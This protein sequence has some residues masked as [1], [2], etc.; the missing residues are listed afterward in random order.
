VQRWGTL[1]VVVSAIFMLLIDITVV[2]VALP[3]IQSSLGASFT[4]L[5]WVIDAYSLAL[6]TFVLNAGAVADLLG[7]KKVFIAG[8]IAFT[9]SS[10]LCGLA[11]SPGFLIG[12]RAV[13]GIGGSIMF[14]TSLAILAQEYTGRDRGVAFGAWG[15]TAGAAVA[16]GPVVGGLLTTWVGWEWIF[17]VNGPIGV[18]AV[19]AAVRYLHESSD[20]DAARLDWLGMVTLAGAVFLVV[21]A[22]LRGNDNGWTSTSTLACFI[23]GAVLLVLFVIVEAVQKRPMVDLALFRRPAFVGA[24]T[25]AFLLSCSYFGLF[26]YLTLYLQN[27]LGYSPLGAGLR[28]LP[29]SV[30]AFVVAPIAGRL[31]ASV[32]VRLLMAGGLGLISVGV[33]LMTGISPSSSWTA[34]IAGFVVSGIGLGMTN[35]PLASTAI[36]VAPQNRAGMASGINN[37]FR[38]VGLATGVAALGAVFQSQVKD[39]L[40]S[41]LAGTPAAHASGALSGAVS[42]GSVSRVLQQ[43]P[44]GARKQ[45]EA[46]ATTAFVDGLTTLFWICAVLAALGAVLA[47]VLI[48]G[49]DFERH[50]AGSERRAQHA[51]ATAASEREPA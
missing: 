4:E 18:L 14:A 27:I 44:A 9:L 10:I 2:N 1:V 31:S 46:A 7:R 50:Q 20:P 13:Q 47:L 49:S 32:P 23:G 41:A 21:Y 43:V 6:A 42:S 48:R 51:Q 33:L 19:V 25:T 34:L 28:L 3:D 8:L 22:L 39:N 24:Q 26:L 35:P 29:I 5:Q 30:A 37:M 45:V 36:S 16:V 12:A 11:G 38:Q 40:A 15:A 17:F